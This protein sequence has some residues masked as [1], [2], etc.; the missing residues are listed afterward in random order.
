MTCNYLRLMQLVNEAKLELDN[1][2][3]VYADA[4]VWKINSKA[5]RWGRCKGELVGNSKLGRINYMYTIEISEKLLKEN[6][7]DKSVKE[8]IIHELLHTVKG[9]KGH[10]GLWKVLAEKVNHAYGYNI[11]RVSSYEEKGIDAPSNSKLP[12]HKFVC[13]GCGQE[14]LRYKESK[15]TQNYLEYR[16]GKCNSIFEKVF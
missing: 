11:K 3:I 7:S 14:I 8:T 6:V 1:I 13:A 12:K 15:F 9:T 4:I 10:T 5:Q 16:C 2:N